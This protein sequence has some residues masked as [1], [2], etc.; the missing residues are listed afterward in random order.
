MSFTLSLHKM[1]KS[2]VYGLILTLIIFKYLI[3]PFII[4][5]ILMLGTMYY[6][7]KTKF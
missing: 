2:Y 5:T 1:K 6:T 3:L 7:F 4:S